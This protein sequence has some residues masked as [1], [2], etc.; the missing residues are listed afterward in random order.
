MAAA[1]PS[2]LGL[3]VFIHGALPV[4]NHPGEQAAVEAGRPVVSARG[5][6]DGSTFRLNR[7]AKTESSNGL[8]SPG[9]VG[10][11]FQVLRSG[12]EPGSGRRVR[13]GFP[14]FLGIALR[15]HRSVK[16]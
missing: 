10:R 12:S 16:G 14:H 13:S 4:P 7:P 8:L 6:R 9:S 15:T 1:C 3:E 11:R 2:G 5:A